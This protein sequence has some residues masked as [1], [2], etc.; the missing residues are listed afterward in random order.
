MDCLQNANFGFILDLAQMS[1]LLRIGIQE[2]VEKRC[3]NRS[4]PPQR[5]RKNDDAFDATR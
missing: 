5:R 4:G 1:N 3:G 2:S